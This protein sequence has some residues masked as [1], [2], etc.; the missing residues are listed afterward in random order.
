M[1][2]LSVEQL[3]N[4][5]S[6]YKNP[7]AKIDRMRRDKELFRI[8]RGIYTRDCGM[9]KEAVSSLVCGPSYVSFEDALSRY[10]LIPEYVAECSCAMFGKQRNT[11]YKNDFGYYSFTNIPKKAFPYGV[12]LYEYGGY[13]WNMAV[14][15]KAICDLL[16]T[17]RQLKNADDLKGFLFESMRIEEDDF[18]SLDKGKMA[19]LA[20][21][22]D[23][24]NLK[25]LKEAVS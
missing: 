7:D 17:R 18:D 14:P 19:F 4:S 15:E 8:R 13:C 10:G 12:E 20:G 1:D 23:H 24:R 21:L 11:I 25:L 6:R 22:Y 16:Y 2:I 5:L 9:I 3:R